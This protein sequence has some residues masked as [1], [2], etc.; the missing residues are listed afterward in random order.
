MLEISTKSN[1]YLK[2]NVYAKNAELEGDEN[3]KTHSLNQKANQENKPFGEAVSLELSNEYVLEKSTYEDMLRESKVQ[4]TLKQGSKGNDVKT[5]QSNL[6]YLGYNVGTADGVFGAKTKN[7]VIAYQRAHGLE[8]DGIA[9]PAT[10]NSIASSV[11]LKKA[12]EV[13]K[14]LGVLQQGSKGE[15]VAKL[16]RNLVALGYNPKGTDGIFGADTKAAVMLF[17]EVCGLTADG[18]VGKNTNDAI[19]RALSNKNAGALSRGLISSEV[20]SLQNNL[21]KLGYYSGSADGIFGA[22]TESAVK[23]FQRAYGLV[24]DGVAGSGTKGKI[25]NLLNGSHSVKPVNPKTG[26]TSI[27]AILSRLD[28]GLN[29]TGSKKTAMITAAR[30]LLVKG[31]DS[32]FVAGVLGNIQNEGTPG[33]FESSNY[34]SNPAAKPEYLRYMDANYGYATKCSGRT[35]SEV[36]IS[37]ASDMSAK[38]E[39]SGYKG[40]FGLG[41]VQWTGGRATS[42]IE[43]YKTK[44][45]KNNP[46]ES[47]CASIEAS[48]IVKEL[49][50]SYSYVYKNWKMGQATA[51]SAGDIVCR[52]YE[53]PRYKNTEAVSRAA[54]ANEIY[55]IM[56]G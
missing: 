52:E 34:K 29:V 13:T 47:E 30:E 41:M 5:L 7:A 18:V 44:T 56:M 21:K 51:A 8:V 12:A 53:R 9:G 6:N 16:Q 32:K 43:F 36:G 11:A 15:A 42:L 35:L 48:Y 46:T 54:N 17:Q 28:K 19:N 33:K 22:G 4:R 27:D 39:A 31:Y 40:K 26:D 2:M 37:V 45:S 10:Q 50:T 14:N 1:N 25:A 55:K 38:A 24:Q 20:T 3:L 49:E 23:R